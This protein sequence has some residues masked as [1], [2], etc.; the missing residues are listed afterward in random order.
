MLES[1][2]AQPAGA[3]APAGP[4]R[5]RDRARRRVRGRLVHLHRRAWAGRSTASSTARR[6]TSR[7]CPRVPATSTRCRTTAHHPRLGR[8]RH[9]RPARG[10]PGVRRR[11]DA[12]RLRHRRP[13]ASWSAATARPGFALN[14]TEHPSPH[15]RP[16]PHA[17]RRRA[18]RRRGP[19]SPSTRAPPTRPATRSATRST[20]VTPGDPPTMKAT[21]T[22]LVEFGS[23]GGLVGATLTIFDE[24]AMQ[25]LFFDGKDVYT[26]ISV[27]TADGASQQQSRPTRQRGAARGRRRRPPATTYAEENKSASPTTSR[28]INIFLLVFAAVAVV[29]STFLIVNTFSILVAQRSRELA[30]LRAMGAS[31]RQVTRVGADRGVRRRLRSAPRSGSASATCWRSGSASLFGDVRSRPGRRRL[32][33]QAAHRHR[34]LRSSAWS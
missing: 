19:R 1:H 4:Q 11:P 13:T 17:D 3:Q 20:L 15:R 31:R 34:L 27:N 21:L 7:S 26:S 5:V 30:L 16:D 25:D 28:F 9:R 18:A 2:L 32:P 12:G 33:G 6:P 10:R 29:V 23:K 8:R 14:Y 24:Q 22:G